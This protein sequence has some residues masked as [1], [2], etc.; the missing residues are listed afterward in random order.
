MPV[1]R[2]SFSPAASPGAARQC[3]P[4]ALAAQDGSMPL[5]AEIED[6]LAEAAET[7]SLACSEELDMGRSPAASSAQQLS[8]IAHLAGAL[9]SLS[10]QVQHS[11]FM[12]SPVHG[13]MYLAQ[14]HV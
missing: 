11:I 7:L 12:A 3:S 13:L 9:H 4:A 5:A 6:A 2:L 14:L 1:C 10:M 8:P